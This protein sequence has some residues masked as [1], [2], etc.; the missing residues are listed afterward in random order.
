MKRKQKSPARQAGFTLVEI[1]IVLVIIGL[2]LGGVLKGQELIAQAKI[3]N[4]I[5]DFNGIS[6]AVYGYQDRYRKLPGDDNGAGRWTSNAGNGNGVIEGCY[7]GD[8][9]CTGGVTGGNTAESLLFWNHLRHAGFVGGATVTGAPAITILPQNAVGGY[10][11]VQTGAYGMGTLVLCSAN[12]SGK[13]ASAIDSAID[14][15]LPNSGQIRAASP[16]G[17]NAATPTAA[18]TAYTADDSTLY[19]V[20][21]SL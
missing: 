10:I 11:G 18:A 7:N 16:T 13:I 21:K 19:V 6:S 14:D 15:G 5:N 8:T 9:T 2:L 12:I 3:K 1:A 4:L 17:L 20:C